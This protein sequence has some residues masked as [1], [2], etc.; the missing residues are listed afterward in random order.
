MD[1]SSTLPPVAA[2]RGSDKIWSILSHL[3]SFVGLPLLLPLVVYLAMKGESD[4]VATNA[5]EAL[6][7]HLSLLIY[8]LCC[9]PLIFVVVGLPLLIVMWLASLIFAIVA[10]V[11]RRT[12]A[13]IIIRLPFG[14]STKPPSR[15]A[16]THRIHPH[17]YRVTKELGTVR[18]I[19]VR[20][21]S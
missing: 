6:N 7:F 1:S 3:S 2:H 21:R 13:A 15:H 4:Y 9:I 14:S 12:A 10:A 19:V 17:G 18:G 20:S 16:Q 5:R 11:R 8:S